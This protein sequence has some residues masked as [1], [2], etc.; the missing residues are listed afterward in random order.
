MLINLRKGLTMPCI[1]LNPEICRKVDIVQALEEIV[2]TGTK[3][4]PHLKEQRKDARYPDFLA[5]ASPR[6]PVPV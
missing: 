3:P 6:T 5:F 2:R 4:Q 1:L